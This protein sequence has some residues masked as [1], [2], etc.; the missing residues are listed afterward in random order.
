MVA[1]LTKVSQLPQHTAGIFADMSIDGPPIGT[2]VA[3]IDR[4]KNLPNRKTMGKQNPYCAARLGKEAKKTETDMRGGQ[5]PK[6]DQELRFTVHE[7]PDYYQLKVSVFNDDKKT[8]LIGETTIDLKNVVVPGGGQNDLWHGL[9]CK[10][11]YAGDIRIELTY[12]DTRPKDEAVIERRKEAEKVETRAETVQSG[13]SGP[14]QAKP[15]KRRP[16]PAD[17]TGS[18]PSRPPSSDRVVPPPSAL[19]ENHS[20]PTRQTIQEP[21]PQST[22]PSQSQRAYE[23]PDDFPTPIKIPPLEKFKSC[24]SISTVVVPSIPSLLEKWPT[25]KYQNIPHNTHHQSL[26]HSP[27]HNI[28]QNVY[29]YPLEPTPIPPPRDCYQTPPRQTTYSMQTPDRYNTSPSYPPPSRGSSYAATDSP[30]TQQSPEPPINASPND[31]RSHYH[32][33]STSHA[34]NDVFR[35]SP[36]RH[37]LNNPDFPPRH[38]YMQPHLQNEEEEGPPPP[39]PVHRQIFHPQQHLQQLPTSIPAKPPLSSAP[40]DYGHNQNALGPIPMPEPLSIGPGRTSPL[41][42]PVGEQGQQYIAYSSSYHSQNLSFSS[43]DREPVSAYSSSPTPSYMN[44]HANTNVNS[45]ARDRMAAAPVQEQPGTSD[46]DIKVMA[47]VPSALVPGYK[48]AVPEEA[49][50]SMIYH[51]NSYVSPPPQPQLHQQPPSPQPHQQPPSPQPQPQPQTRPH[52]QPSRTSPRPP[53]LRSIPARKSVSPHPHQPPA[54]RDPTNPSLPGVPFSPDSYNALNPSVSTAFTTSISSSIPTYQESALE[55]DRQREVD[56][57]RDLG[58]I[59][60]D[61]GRVIDPSDHLPTDTWAPEP[62]RKFATVSGSG[63]AGVG[64]RAEVVVRFKHAGQRDGASAGSGGRGRAVSMIGVN[65]SVGEGNRH[66]RA[67]LQKRETL[68]P[69]PVST[70]SRPQSYVHVQHSHDTTPSPRANGIITNN[71]TTPLRSH[72]PYGY[73]GTPTASTSTHSPNIRTS[74]SPSSFYKPSL[75]GPPIPAKVPVQPSASYGG[76]EMDAFSEELRRIDIGVGSGGCVGGGGRRGRVSY[77]GTGGRE[78]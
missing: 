75:T 33:Y 39:P 30:Q 3:I 15:S 57:L 72:D 69:A 56:K 28:G 19:R 60:G 37:S 45:Y 10:G 18:S 29:D 25:P 47:S 58:P 23:T 48:A 70:T 2:L 38:E 64:K 36:L 1:K 59:I 17:P 77:V 66:T 43:V 26:D 12:Y 40:A 11:K 55:A 65:G 21:P 63:G 31:R 20:T 9:Q 49:E 78:G 22:P 6:W 46:G 76:G 27:L 35:D 32:R 13:L 74:P 14:R 54:L 73:N 44:A 62:E 4:A 52:P 68:Q 34:N 42:M 41:P 51:N 53:D 50:R 61:D 67:K 24:R 8:D 71:N 7:S 16:L 5:R